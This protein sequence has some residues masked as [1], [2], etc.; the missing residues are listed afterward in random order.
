VN[1]LDL[2]YARSERARSIL[3][4]YFLERERDFRRHGE[5]RAG[6]AGAAGERGD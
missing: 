4:Q 3:C 6:A 2:S 1:Q 5:D